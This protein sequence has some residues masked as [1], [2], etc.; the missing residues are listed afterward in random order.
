MTMRRLESKNS[1]RKGT[2]ATKRKLAASG[3][4]RFS[5]SEAKARLSEVLRLTRDGQSV[6]VTDHGQDVARIEAIAMPDQLSLIPAMSSFS[7]VRNVRAPERVKPPMRSALE[8]LQ[9]DRQ[10][11]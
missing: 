1:H 8:L 7:E 4:E 5:V 9:E 2:P 3:T 6:I 11:R 10:R